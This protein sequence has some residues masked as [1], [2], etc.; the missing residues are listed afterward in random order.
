MLLDLLG[1]GL[2]V[3]IMA[4]VRLPNV[5]IATFLFSGLLCYDLFWVFFSQR[6]FETNVMV[7]VATKTAENP[8]EVMANSLSMPLSN[9][10]PALS[11]PAK[12]MFPSLQRPDEF[13]MLGL[14]DVVLPG[15]LVAHNLRYDRFSEENGVG[16]RGRPSRYFVTTLVGYVV[17][18]FVAILC[19]EKYRTAQPALIYLIPATLGPTMAV[20]W[21]RGELW[22]LWTGAS[23]GTSDEVIPLDGTKLAH[24]P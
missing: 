22:D 20:G 21:M 15:I 18:L 23:I 3:F 24:V 17:G 6:F 14:G 9:K 11:I 16:S 19:S 7:N 4:A 1:V 13:S 5:R 12:L 10:L 2:C 8:I